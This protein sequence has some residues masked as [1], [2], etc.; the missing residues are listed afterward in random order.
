MLYRHPAVQA[1]AVI[2]QPHPH[3]GEAPCAFVELRSGQTVTADEIIAH[4][5]SHLAGFKTPKW[6][7]IQD[8]PKTA[9]GK[10][11]KFLLREAA[12]ALGSGA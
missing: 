3:W 10:I 9:T 12:K 5:R 7:V 2:A 8:L 1:A 11:Q 4:C 6:V